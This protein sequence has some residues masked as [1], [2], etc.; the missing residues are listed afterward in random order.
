MANEHDPKEAPDTGHEWDG[1]R[2][3]KNDPPRWWMTGLYIAPV[4]VLIYFVLYPSIPLVNDYTRGVLGW[5]QID[6]YRRGLERIK[7]V[8]APYERKVAAMT[9]GEILEDPGMTRYSLAASRVTF[10]DNCAPCHGSGGEGAPGFPVLAD[11]DWLYGGTVEN[12]METI[13]SGREGYMP[14]YRDTLSADEIEDLVRYV[15]GLA[16]GRVHE[17]GREVFMGRTSGGADC[18]VCHGEDARGL[19]EMGGANLTDAIW[20]FEG[21]DEGVRGTIMYGVNQ[22][23]PQSRK[24]VMPAFGERLGENDIRKLAVRVWSLGGGMEE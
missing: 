22:D 23:H 15:T 21:T 17:P 14:G 5:T 7:A 16:A 1:I 13:A 3:L 9:A 24:A 6:E 20:R 19:E 10:G 12:I 4:F 11:D 8:R 18:Y 2:E